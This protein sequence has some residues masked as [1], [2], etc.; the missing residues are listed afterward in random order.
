MNKTLGLLLCGSEPAF[1]LTDCGMQHHNDERPN[2][3]VIMLDD[4]GSNDF[5]FMGCPDLQTTNID[6]LSH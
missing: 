6:S 3:L 1:I 2:V 4:A 5:G